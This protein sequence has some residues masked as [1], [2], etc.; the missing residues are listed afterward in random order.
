MPD[1][2]T[3]YCLFNKVCQS[4]SR[5]SKLST[6]SRQHVSEH[7]IAYTKT[8]DKYPPLLHMII[9]RYSEMNW[10]LILQLLYVRLGHERP[11]HNFCK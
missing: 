6:Y 7:Y 1:R 8:S 4:D 9:S 2:L 11:K 10:P 5:V 3:I